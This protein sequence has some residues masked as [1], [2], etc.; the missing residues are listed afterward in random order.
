MAGQRAQHLFAKYN[1]CVCNLLYSKCAILLSFPPLCLCHLLNARPSSFISDCS[2]PSTPLESH[3][4]TPLESHV[5][6]MYVSTTYIHR[7]AKFPRLR[8]QNSRTGARNPQ[9]QLLTNSLWAAGRQ[10]R[11]SRSSFVSVCGCVYVCVLCVRVN[12]SAPAR[13]L[14]RTKPTAPRAFLRTEARRM[15]APAQRLMPYPTRR[16][17]RYPTGRRRH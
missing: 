11:Q 16:G 8:S 5:W 10:A 15:H 7:A 2:H 14:R 17:C 4:S 12:D 3:P 6:R 9:Q 1:H 13:E